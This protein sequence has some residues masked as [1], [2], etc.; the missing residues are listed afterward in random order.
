LQVLPAVEAHVSFHCL[1]GGVR[2][3]IGYVCV[4]ERNRRRVCSIAWMVVWGEWLDMCVWE[5]EI[6][7]VCVC[8][9]ADGKEGCTYVNV[10]GI[11]SWPRLLPRLEE[12]IIRITHRHTQT[13]KMQW[14]YQKYLWWE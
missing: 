5:R 3:V 12:G 2:G 10:C 7:G 4:R 14:V 13:K 1:D 11:I 8:V 6:E 9:H